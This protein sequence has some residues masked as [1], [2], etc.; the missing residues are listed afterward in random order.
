MWLTDCERV[1]DLLVDGA[2]FREVTVE[3]CGAVLLLH[4]QQRDRVRAEGDGLEVAVDGELI[5]PA[6]AGRHKPG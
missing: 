5:A 4:A 3:A 2:L 6:A 1:D